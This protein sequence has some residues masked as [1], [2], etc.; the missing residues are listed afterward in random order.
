VI[1]LPLNSAG[2]YSMRVSLDGEPTA[3]V[4]LFVSNV[5]AVS[6]QPNMMVS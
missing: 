3:D 5:Q 6:M 4:R 2:L 1:D